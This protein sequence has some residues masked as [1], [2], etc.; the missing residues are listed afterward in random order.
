[1]GGVSGTRP[2]PRHSEH[3]KNISTWGSSDVA[4]VYAGP[5]TAR[6]CAPVRGS[7]GRFLTESGGEGETTP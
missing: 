3:G 7:F 4:R 6:Q 5:M 1:M 2:V